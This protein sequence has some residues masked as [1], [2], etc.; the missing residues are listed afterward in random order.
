MKRR[1]QNRLYL[2]PENAV[3][4]G[5]RQVTLAVIALAGLALIALAVVGVLS[6]MRNNRE[7]AALP[8]T[9]TAVPSPTPTKTPEPTVTPTVTV[10]P[11]PPPSS[12]EH[13][14]Q[15]G[16]SMFSIAALYGLS[17]E[18]LAQAN[19][20]PEE[21][22]LL[23]G[24]SLTIPLPLDKRGRWHTVQPGETLTGIAEDYGVTEG[25]IQSANLMG[26]SIEIYAGEQLRIPGVP[27]EEATAEP[28]S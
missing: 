28:D 18:M 13:T 23:E 16:E 24:M 15:T 6:L 14:V 10:T 11:E 3:V 12:F 8:P 9:E 4:I 20:M 1:Q 5:P 21:S 26:E 22:V 2:K 25:A 27:G 19:N 17:T 7:P